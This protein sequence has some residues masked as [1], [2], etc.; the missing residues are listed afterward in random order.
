MFNNIGILGLGLIGG[1]LAKALKKYACDTT[2]YGYNRHTQSA[3]DAKSQGVI[4]IVVTDFKDFE[5][6][7]LIVLCAPVKV[8]LLLFEQVK[9]YLKATSVITDVGST[10]SDIFTAFSAMDYKGYFI[11][12]HPMAGSEK[13]GFQATRAELFENAYY[14]LTP[15][16]H[17]PLEYIESMKEMIIAIHGLP[18]V[19]NPH[20]HDYVV[21]AISHVPH[22]LA[23]ALVNMVENLD[24]DKKEMYTL[25]AGGFKDFTRI[26]SSSPDMWKQICMSNQESVIKI[27]DTYQAMIED[28]KTSLTFNKEEDLYHLFHQSRT[29]RNTFQHKIRGSIEK[30]HA[31]TVN[32]DDEPGVIATIATHL[33]V[34]NIS[35]KNIGIN[36]NREDYDGV[37]EILFYDDPSKV[38]S[39]QLIKGLN[40]KV[41]D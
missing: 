23:S 36:N 25:A 24:S 31:I 39:V 8:N 37:L 33:A 17:C 29:Y 21:A 1:S 19:L 40:Y 18:V 13:S 28:I 15:E 35:I 22:I 2:I 12:G 7:D 5:N 32:I 30:S 6:C 20:K 14:I 34:N 27:L 9:P 41:I 4:D 38:K 3:I 11:G 16:D 26:A 10:K